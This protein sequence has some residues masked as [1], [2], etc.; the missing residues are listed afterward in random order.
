MKIRI[1]DQVIVNAGKDRGKTGE[2]MKI[3]LK[4]DRVHVDGVNSK[5]RNIKAREG[6]A[7]DRIQIFAPIHISNVSLIDPKSGK[8]TRVGYEIK[9]K[10]KIRVAKASG[11]PIVKA[12]K[13][14]KKEKA[15]P[16]TKK[17]PKVIKA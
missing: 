8:A 4:R 13:A 1:G 11:Q 16:A 7:G 2:V 17:D 9:D 6:Q 3:D 14:A 12:A 15:K 5:I 10:E